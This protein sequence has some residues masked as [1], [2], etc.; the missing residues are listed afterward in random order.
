[1]AAEGMQSHDQSCG[2]CPTASHPASKKG[3]INAP[4]LPKPARCAKSDRLLDPA[5]T[6]IAQEIQIPAPHQVQTCADQADGPI[7]QIMSLPSFSGRKAH[8]AEQDLRNHPIRFAGKVAVERTED[9]D[10]PLP[11]LRR[12]TVGWAGAGMASDATPQLQG[13]FGTRSKVCIERNDGRCGRREIGAA[14]QDRSH[15]TIVVMSEPIVTIVSM[16][17]ERRYQRANS[18]CVG[19]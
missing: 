18:A 5:S 10:E 2:N 14:D 6:R 11:P 17:L 19:E 9:E 4:I 3:R 15:T 7:A 12:Q 8:F 13:C 16:A 1:M